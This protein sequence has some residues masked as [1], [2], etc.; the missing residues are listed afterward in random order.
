[1]K[2]EEWMRTLYER[3]VANT[4]AARKKRIRNDKNFESLYK[5]NEDVLAG[6][7]QPQLMSSTSEPITVKV[8]FTSP[9]DRGKELTATWLRRNGWFVVDNFGMNTV[10]V[11]CSKKHYVDC[12]LKGFWTIETILLLFLFGSTLWIY[13]DDKQKA[14][15]KESLGRAAIEEN[16]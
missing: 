6:L 4:R 12:R 11:Y 13:L 10:D 2:P 7:I 9:R 15:D 1:M 3:E 8:M 14:N 16:S 5:S